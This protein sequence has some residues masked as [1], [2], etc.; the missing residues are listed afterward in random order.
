MKIVGF[1]FTKIILIQSLEPNEVKTGRINH[2]YI[3]AQISESN[4]NIPVE[5]IN[6]FN[7]LEFLQIL[8]DLE[9]EASYKGEIPLLHVECHG[10]LKDGLEFENGSTLSWPDISAALTRLNRACRFNL[11]AVFSACFGGHFLGQM[12]AINPAPCWCMIAPTNTI[13]PGEILRVFRTFY[14]TLF[15]ESDVG[16]ALSEI[17]KMQMND[18]RWFGQTAEL[19]F[20]RV[21]VGYIE[22][23]CTLTAVNERAKKM[24]RQLRSEGKH[25]SIGSLTRMLRQRNRQS[26]LNN[27]F[28]QYFMTKEVPENNLR[29][30]SAKQ[31]L[32]FKLSELRN[33]GK[34]V[35]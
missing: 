4:L 12:G 15:R 30:N 17:T 1:S 6:C 20:E 28:E 22:N 31:R 33:S 34:Y 16:K 23:H 24:Y 29:F 27:Y 21:V 8:T 2:E 18:G 35:L 25:Q 26:L 11:L 19:W 13:D 32:E 7:Y 9:A 3:S 5:V 14:F 10:D